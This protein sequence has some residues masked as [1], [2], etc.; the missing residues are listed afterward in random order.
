MHNGFNSHV[1]LGDIASPDE[2]V[3]LRTENALLRAAW[4]RAVESYPQ[5]VQMPPALHL[6]WEKFYNDYLSSF[7]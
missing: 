5:A 3:K 2:V 7:Q 4:K 6:W 1:N